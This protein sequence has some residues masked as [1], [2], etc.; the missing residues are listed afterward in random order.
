MISW[1]T[2]EQQIWYRSVKNYEVYARHQ[3]LYLYNN[4]I[5]DISALSVLRN[6]IGLSLSGNQISDIS[7]LS[8]LTNLTHLY[9]YDNQI[10]DI[11]A[12]SGLTNL[13]ALH[14]NKNPVVENKSREE[15]MEVLSGAENLT[16]VDF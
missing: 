13:E 2:E 12:M 16:D 14:L 15:I 9:L 10:S 4:Q 11:S 1:L 7:A 8:G 3:Y 5:S 6:L